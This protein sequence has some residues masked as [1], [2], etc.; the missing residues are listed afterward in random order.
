M[1]ELPEKMKAVVTH[2]PHDYRFEEV[3]MPVMVLAK[4]LSRWKFAE[5]VLATSKPL[6]A[7]RSFGARI[8]TLLFRG[9]GHRRP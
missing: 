4:Y 5:Y 3:E 1:S 6:K 7:V 8:K 9:A 2:G